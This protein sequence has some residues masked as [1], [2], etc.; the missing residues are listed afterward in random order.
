MI[1]SNGSRGGVVRA[2]HF[3]VKGFSPT[4]RETAALLVCF[5]FSQNHRITESLGFKG[6]LKITKLQSPQ[7]GGVPHEEF[8]Y[9]KRKEQ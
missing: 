9:P 4:R 8:Q 6:T 3:G 5:I 2:S 7:T 1:F